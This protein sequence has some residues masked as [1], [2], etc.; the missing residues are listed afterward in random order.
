MDK[1]LVRWL[2]TKSK[3]FI[4]LTLICLYVVVYGITN[5]IPT[6]YGPFE[7]PTLFYEGNLPVIPWTA[8]IYLSMFLFVTMA[9]IPIQHKIIVQ[10]SV[11]YIYL[12]I[13]HS[14]IFIFFPTIYPREEIINQ[15]GIFNWALT[16]LIYP[17]DTPRN[18]FPSLHVSLPFAAAFIWRQINKKTGNIFLVWAILIAIS[19]ITTKQH[20]LLDVFGAIFI[21]FVL[22]KI[23][24]KNPQPSFL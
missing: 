19:T 4:F 15:S 8:I 22:V 7:L 12:L 10:A 23:K 21:S 2:R 3:L 14:L 9:T 11:V 20:Y 18:C 24:F 5:R 16:D 1:L 17:L 13:F 6:F